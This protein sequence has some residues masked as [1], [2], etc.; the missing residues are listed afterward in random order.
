MNEQ[1]I[2]LIEQLAQKLGTTSEYLWGILILQAKVAAIEG[3]VFACLTLAYAVFYIRAMKNKKSF[4]YDCDGD[5]TFGGI[6]ASFGAIVSV[7]VFAACISEV[8]TAVFNPEYYAL[9]IILK[10]LQ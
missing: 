6:A 1:T 10:F 5:L 2:K 3:C 4:L 7:F 8:I 9:K